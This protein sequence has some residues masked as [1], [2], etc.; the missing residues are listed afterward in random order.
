MP[1]IDLLIQNEYQGYLS[2][3]IGE[4]NYY[5]NLQMDKFNNLLKQKHIS[6][7]DINKQFVGGTIFYAPSLVFDN[8]LN[9]V[10]NN[11]YRSYLLNNLY[12]NNTINRDFSPIH[13]LERLFGVINI[14]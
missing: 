3:C 10:K 7:I 11:N 12:E 6:K 13:F 5:I 2:N 4:P 9:F 1:L 8:V 14:Y